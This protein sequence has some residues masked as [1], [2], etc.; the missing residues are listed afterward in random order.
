MEI[1][2][3]EHL[4]FTDK[5]HDY[6]FKIVYLATRSEFTH[7]AISLD[8]SFNELYT[9]G[10]K[11]SRLMLPAGFAIESVYNGILGSSDNMKCAVY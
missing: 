4:Y 11:Y 3:E 2:H 6:M 10:R 8:S 5:E 7:A 9:F 1:R